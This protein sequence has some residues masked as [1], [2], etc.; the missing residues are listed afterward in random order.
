[1]AKKDPQ[2]VTQRRL[3]ELKRIVDKVNAL[4]FDE[5]KF[6][7]LLKIAGRDRE[8]FRDLLWTELQK[9]PGP[10]PDRDSAVKDVEA[11]M[12]YRMVL[13][14]LMIEVDG[15]GMPGAVRDYYF[16]YFMDIGLPTVT[17]GRLR[18]NPSTGLVDL[19]ERK[20]G[21]VRTLRGMNLSSLRMCAVCR[22]IFW[23]GRKDAWTCGDR[24]SN[25][26]RQRR[27]RKQP[28]NKDLELEKANK[29]RL[30]KRRK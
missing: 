21:I 27:Y 28:S 20:R 9:H 30:E 2:N 11:A 6:D 10:Y 25:T 4:P 24:C 19:V 29:T 23:A 8:K 26:L 17:S 14:S 12:V 16:D 18:V 3:E 13:M 22:Y 1:M 5:S 7:E 15:N